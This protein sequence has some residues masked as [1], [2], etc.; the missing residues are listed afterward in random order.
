[1]KVA[2]VGNCQANPVAQYLKT[3]C[4][5]LELLRVTVI[6]LSNAAS[7][8]ADLENLDQADIIF[9]QLVNDDYHAA[10][11]ATSKLRERYSDK[12]VTWPNLFFNGN[13]ADLCYITQPGGRL[14][15]PLDVYQNR[16]LF[17]TWHE[18]VPVGQARN[19]LAEKYLE[20]ADSLRASVTA[21]LTALEQR[22]E[23][24]DVKMSDIISNH[25]KSTRLFFTFNHPSLKLLLPLVQRMVGHV[26]I[27][28]DVELDAA[29]V[30]EPLAQFVGPTFSELASVLDL[31]YQSVES[32][33]GV[34]FGIED[35]ELVS[36]KQKIYSPDEL[37]KLFYIAYNA[38]PIDFEA[39]VY[40]PSYSASSSSFKHA[41]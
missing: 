35:G 19:R 5:S 6:H 17:E 40:T 12:L 18:G 25:W 38:Q 32:A 14:I 15:G 21:S 37:I 7:A 36:G 26:K 11:L 9:S 4:P 16:F 24:C 20:N 3:M 27:S 8:D 34:E 29:F 39:C 33:K 30:Q 2:V 1:M 31:D 41:A 13:C 23:S 28:A 22:D 10:H